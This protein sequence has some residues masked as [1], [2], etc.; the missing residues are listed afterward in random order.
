MN[1][2]EADRLLTFFTEERGKIRAVAR[3]ARRTKSKFGASLEP[4]TCVHLVYFG[5]ESA[6]LYRVNSA[7]IIRSFDGIRMDLEKWTYGLF[8]AEIIDKLLKERETLPPLYR[9]ALALLGEIEAD[10]RTK[11]HLI[12]FQ[13]R[14][15]S[16]VGYRPNLARC[17]HCGGNLFEKGGVLGPG[18]QGI[19]CPDCSQGAAGYRLSPG[20]LRYL[21]RAI[22]LDS[23]RA[24]RLVIPKSLLSE[25][26]RFLLAYV[27]DHSGVRL[28][29]P[30]FF[31]L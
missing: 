20:S 21:D 5:K 24:M 1:L 17:V 18:G 12:L 16:A 31:D 27:A 15:L 30:K 11:E 23:R 28:Q 25:I 3:G 10:G 14:V 7:D 8:L 29:V 2:G 4:L 6:D 26:Q 19:S 13:A 22:T 9:L